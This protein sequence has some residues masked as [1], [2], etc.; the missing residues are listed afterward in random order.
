[1]CVNHSAF[2]RRLTQLCRNLRKREMK[3]LLVK[4]MQSWVRTHCT[5]SAGTFRD[6]LFNQKLVS[7]PEAS[8]TTIQHKMFGLF[9]K[10]FV[11]STGTVFGVYLAQNYRLP[12]VGSAAGSLVSPWRLRH[13]KCPC[14]PSSARSQLAPL[15]V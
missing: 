7:A 5:Q 6:T 3:R 9:R 4:Y 11:F 12:D 15:A 10:A 14:Q 2:G 13:N 8:Q 1:M